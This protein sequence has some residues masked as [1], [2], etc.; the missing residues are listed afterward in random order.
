M[1]LGRTISTITLAV[2]L[3]NN[4]FNAMMPDRNIYSTEFIVNRD[5]MITSEYI[6]ETVSVDVK[7]SSRKMREEAGQALEEMFK[8]AKEEGISLV[9]VSGYRS[10]FTQRTIYNRKLE[11][12]KSVEA[13]NQYVALPGSSEHQ[14]GLAMDVG[15]ASGSNLNAAFQ[16]S[17]EGK[18]IADNCY[19]FGFIIRYIEGYEKVTGYSYEPWHVRFVGKQ[20]ALEI[21]TL[22]NPPY[23]YYVSQHRAE[24]YQHYLS[25]DN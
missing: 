6:P 15:K 22:G 11:K 23:E 8:V 5:H 12:V 25:L 9:S 14:L 10:Y 16:N 4:S 21:H 24:L 7:G 13:A 2:S 3:L 17:K 1:S 18:W 20:T 19:K